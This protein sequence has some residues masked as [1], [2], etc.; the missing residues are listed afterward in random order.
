MALNGWKSK[1]RHSGRHL[2]AL[3][4]AFLCL[5]S[6]SFKPWDFP[7]QSLADQTTIFVVNHGWHTGLVIPGNVLGNKLEVISPY[8]DSP[9]YYELGWGDAGFYQAED[10]TAS[11]AVKALLWPSDSVMHVVALPMDPVSYFAGSEVVALTLSSGGLNRLTSHI[12]A[13]FKY[14]VNGRLEK[15]RPGLYG[16]SLFF[17]G[18][19]TYHGFN[20]CN[21]WTADV[22][23]SGGVPIDDWLSLTAGS[24]MVQA[25]QALQGR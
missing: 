18:A 9:P 23:A 10:I 2:G 3:C 24:V 19:G 12:A 4:I 13:S 14:G 7:P 21:T 1:L 11:L 15:M 22:L 8:F 16:Q 6:S 25:R 5:C 20:T 17:V